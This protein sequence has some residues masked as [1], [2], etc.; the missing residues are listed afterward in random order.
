[1]SVGSFR[2]YYII[3]STLLFSTVLFPIFTFGNKTYPFI[4]GL[5]YSLF[6]IIL[7]IVITFIAVLILYF[8]DPDKEEV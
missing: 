4:L 2:T 6:W 1:M 5:P 3:I 8:I 7:W